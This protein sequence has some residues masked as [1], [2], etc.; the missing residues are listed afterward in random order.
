MRDEQQGIGP[1]LA[2]SGA[3]QGT[4]GPGKVPTVTALTGRASLVGT[5]SVPQAWAATPAGAT[6][7]A[8]PTAR[9]TVPA[10]LTPGMF[11]EAMLGTLAGRAV[12]NAAGGRQRPSV[13]PRSPPAG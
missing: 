4:I 1:F 10:A 11:G 12:N 5:L 7:A 9:A 8:P 2:V 13:I 6:G 3:A